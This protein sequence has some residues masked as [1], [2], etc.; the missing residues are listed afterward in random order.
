MH[1]KSLVFLVLVVLFGVAG[2]NKEASN[3]KEVAVVNTSTTVE[4]VASTPATK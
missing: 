1:S 2:C 4:P 3:A